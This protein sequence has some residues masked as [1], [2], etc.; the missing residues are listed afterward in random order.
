MLFLGYDPGGLRAAGAA[1]VKAEGLRVT[2]VGV[3]TFDSVGEAVDFF[4]RTAG[5]GRVEAAGIDTYLSWAT[6]E[7]GWRAADR[8]LRENYP[9]VQGSVFSSNSASGSMAVQGM[10]LALKLR[11]VWPHIIL[12]ETHPKVLYYAL[13][14]KKYKS[15]QGILDWLCERVDLAGKRIQNEHEWDAVLSAWATAVAFAEESGWQDL[16]DLPD[17]LLFPAGQVTYRAGRRSRLNILV[18]DAFDA[19]GCSTRR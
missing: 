15:G 8:F 19:L 2:L 16:M 7:C 12:N 10:A 1:V 4:T 9:Q 11:Q 13:S 3:G 5:Q 6:G 14:G 17:D 18:P